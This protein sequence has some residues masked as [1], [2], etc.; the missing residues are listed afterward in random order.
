MY[1]KIETLLEAL[2]NGD[3]RKVSRC[4][5]AGQDLNQ[6]VRSSTANLYVPLL[7]WALEKNTKTRLMT[8][9]VFKEHINIDATISQYG[10]SWNA[11]G[12]CER[13]DLL[14]WHLLIQA[15]IDLT[16]K[17]SHGGFAIDYLFAENTHLMLMLLSAGSPPPKEYYGKVETVKQIIQG[18]IHGLNTAKSILIKI[19]DNGE[20]EREVLAFVFAEDHLLEALWRI[21]DTLIGRGQSVVTF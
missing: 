11:F 16:Y 4:L 14:S 17:D 8:L 15:G 3:I 7:F 5:K 10:N 9:L 6:T 20:L 12:R 21:N 2:N 1:D 19:F 18:W 13:D